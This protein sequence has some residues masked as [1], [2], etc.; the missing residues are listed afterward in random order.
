[1]RCS[2]VSSAAAAIDDNIY[3]TSG[4]IS[5]PGKPTASPPPLSHPS[6]RHPCPQHHPGGDR[7]ARP[8]ASL[9]VVC[10]PVSAG[11]DAR[12]RGCYERRA[13]EG[14]ARRAR[15]C[16]GALRGRRGGRRSAAVPHNG[17]TQ[18][19]TVCA[20]GRHRSRAGSSPLFS[21]VTLL[22]SVVLYTPV[23]VICASESINNCLASRPAAP[24]HMYTL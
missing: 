24:L 20:R 19:N 12:R 7:R 16:G 23:Y 4:A 5:A 18:P 1:M 21:G 17:P 2:Q 15:V 8:S 9:P 10:R 6:P 11:R 13:G 22:R 3:A 14:A